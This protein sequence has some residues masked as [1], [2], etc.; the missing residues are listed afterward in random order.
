MNRLDEDQTKFGPTHENH[1]LAAVSMV[2]MA[3]Q[4]YFSL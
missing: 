4:D 1:I 2:L 3:T